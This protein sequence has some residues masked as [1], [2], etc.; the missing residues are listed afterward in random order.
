MFLFQ[1][2]ILP[3]TQCLR[4]LP[5]L[6]GVV[7]A[8]VLMLAACEPIELPTDGNGSGG[9][10]GSGG[11]SS[12]AV[13]TVSVAEFLESEYDQQLC[14][15]GYIVGY[16]NGTRMSS[17]RFELPD[18][19]NTNLVLCDEK[20]PSDL[21]G[22]LP[23]QIPT[24]NGLRAAL[25]LYEHPELLGAKVA[26]VGVPQDYMGVVG[27]KKLARYTLLQDADEDDEGGGAEPDDEQPDDT[28]LHLRHTVEF[29]EEGR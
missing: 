8:L 6:L 21:E 2:T 22:C 29:V 9:T 4:R 13:D 1:H 17:T 3:I 5:A 20:D 15:V 25:N 27:L 11:S 7:L 28:Y 16:V 14:V 10:S 26:L 19:A 24:T 18:K 12:A 23:V